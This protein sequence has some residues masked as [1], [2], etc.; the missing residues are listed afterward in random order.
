MASRIIIITFLILSSINFAASQELTMFQGFWGQDYYEDYQKT[1]KERVDLLMKK[2]KTT[3]Q[4]WRKSKKHQIISF[5]ALGAE[6]IFLFWTLRKVS[7]GNNPTI[8]YVGLLAS[9]GVAIG[10]SLIHI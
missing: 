6:T 1:E 10:L 7:N 4:L 9:A 8:P 5:A 2:D 3:N